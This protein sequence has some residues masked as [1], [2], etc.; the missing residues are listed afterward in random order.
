[1]EGRDL[2]CRS[3]GWQPSAL[4]GG[5]VVRLRESP[6]LSVHAV[7]LVFPAVHLDP[8]PLAGRAMRAESRA[9]ASGSRGWP[10]LSVE[11]RDRVRAA[12]GGAWGARRGDDCQ[13]DLLPGGD[14]AKL[15]G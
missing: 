10:R 4:A 5:L 9:H 8:L 1:T 15:Q 2:V 14:A 7:S 13:P 11:H 12:P 3:V 6:A